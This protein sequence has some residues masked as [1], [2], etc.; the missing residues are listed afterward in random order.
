MTRMRS[1]ALVAALALTA[2]AAVTARQAAGRPASGTGTAS[3][4]VGG[5][6]VKTEKGSVYQGGKW[7]DITYGRPQLRG[8]AD[9]F[10]TG[11]D[12]GK[13][14]LAGAPIWRAGANVA[15]RLKTETALMFGS[16]HVP[17]GEYTV[18]I[19]VKPGAWTFV[20]SSWPIQTTFDPKNKAALWGA[21]GYTPEKDVVRVPMVLTTLPYTVETLT[22]NI[23]DV[24]AKGGKFAIQWDKSMATVPFSLM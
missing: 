15:T 17:P 21:Y 1:M 22:W 7:I 24:T 8:R 10:G 12:Y 14:I 18:Y 2:T 19:D 20:L 13:P 9:I 11:A 23:V 4:E 6:W 5:T 16:T 3:A